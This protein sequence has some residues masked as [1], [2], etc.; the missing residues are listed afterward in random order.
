M[1]KRPPLPYFVLKQ[2]LLDRGIHQISYEEILWTVEWLDFRQEI[3]ERDN[4][5]C[6][7]CNKNQFRQLNDEE[8]QQVIIESGFGKYFDFMEGYVDE[9]TEFT[10]KKNTKLP[11]RRRYDDTV[12]LEVHHK[13]YIWN[14]L[15][16]EY[17]KIALTTLCDNCHE[18]EHYK[19]HNIYSDDTLQTK[20]SLV[21]CHRC[22]GRGYLPEYKHVQNGICF[23]CG[24]LGKLLEGTRSNVFDIKI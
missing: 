24:G 5:I 9:P 8:Y 6:T 3:K 2:Y 20:I 18:L 23:N 1:A 16:W 17:D 14:K 4:F 11:S 10:G 12:Q 15:P 22:H 13:Y 19:E 7:N 21:L